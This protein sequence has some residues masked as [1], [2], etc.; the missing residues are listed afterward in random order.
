MPVLLHSGNV[1]HDQLQKAEENL[2]DEDHSLRKALQIVL[3]GPM[4]GCSVKVL[5]N[6]A[7]R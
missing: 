2:M 6:Q 4:D 7:G 5:G 1:L 3:V